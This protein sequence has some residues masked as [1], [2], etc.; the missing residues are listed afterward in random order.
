[1]EDLKIGAAMIKEALDRELVKEGRDQRRRAE[2]KAAHEAAVA[3]VAS[4]ANWTRFLLTAQ[5]DRSNKLFMTIERAERLRTSARGSRALPQQTARQ[6]HRHQLYR[7]TV[8]GVVCLAP[9]I[10][11]QARSLT[12]MATTAKKMKKRR[13]VAPPP[14]L[15]ES[16][17]TMTKTKTSRRHPR[18]D[19]EH[20][21]QAP[22]V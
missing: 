8:Q 17:M 18:L 22:I 20:N 7:T 12:L 19:A 13:S 16:L 3:K 2:E 10:C 15:P 4:S 1:M 14:V 5:Y 11:S 9:D 6:A 21:A